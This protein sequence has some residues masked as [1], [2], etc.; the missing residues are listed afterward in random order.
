MNKLVP[1]YP[2]FFYIGCFTTALSIM[3]DAAGAHRNDWPPLKK[4]N[5]ATASRYGLTSGIGIIIASLISNSFVPALLLLMGTAGF[6]GTIF[7]KNFT[8]RE[9]L[10][11]ITPLGGGMIILGW[12]SLAFL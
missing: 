6:S 12:I 3:L 5:Q 9:D 1:N 10:K 8:D 11:K 2:I 4:F 7:Y